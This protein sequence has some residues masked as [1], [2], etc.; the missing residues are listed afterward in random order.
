[1][2]KLS[3]IWQVGSLICI[4]LEKKSKVSITSESWNTT[5]LYHPVKGIIP[6]KMI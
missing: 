1:M 2:S 6:K 5:T 3:V 4:F